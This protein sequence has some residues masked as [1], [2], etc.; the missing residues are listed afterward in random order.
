MPLFFSSFH[1]FLRWHPTNMLI[2]DSL[3]LS[4][5]HSSICCV[6]NVQNIQILWVVKP[7]T[8]LISIFENDI[9]TP[10][11]HRDKKSYEISCSRVKFI[12]FAID[13]IKKILNTYTH[14]HNTTQLFTNVSIIFLCKWSDDLLD[15]RRKIRTQHTKFA[16]DRIAQSSSSCCAP[17]EWDESREIFSVF[18]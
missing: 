12:D 14:P 13:A 11:K 16:C 2:A 5:A 15:V 6:R 10:K 18:K 1:L 8:K 3:S 17:C 4:L 9:Q 7:C